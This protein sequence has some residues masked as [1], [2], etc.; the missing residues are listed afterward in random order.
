MHKSEII[1]TIGYFFNYYISCVSYVQLFEPIWRI[2]PSPNI[3]YYSLFREQ[4]ATSSTFVRSLTFTCDFLYVSMALIRIPDSISTFFGAHKF[5]VIHFI[6]IGQIGS[7]TDTAL[8]KTFVTTEKKKVLTS[9]FAHSFHLDG[10][11]NTGWN[12]GLHEGH[13]LVHREQTE[14]ILKIM[15]FSRSSSL[16]FFTTH[17]IPFGFATFFKSPFSTYINLSELHLTDSILTHGEFSSTLKL[18]I[19][20]S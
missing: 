4:M 11:E 14:T 13:G 5:S 6:P 18:S 16:I 3:R 9:N 8:Y 19:R 1:F 10:A 12:S 20:E 17:L 2:T 7:G 15:D